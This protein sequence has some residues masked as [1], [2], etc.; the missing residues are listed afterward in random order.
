MKPTEDRWTMMLFRG[1]T[2][3]PLKISV[4]KTTFKRVLLA[5][6]MLSAV[7]AGVLGHYMAQ[8]KQ[9]TTQGAELE[10]LQEELS[11]SRGQ[12]VELFAAVD[13]MRQRVLTIQTLNEKLQ[14]MFGLEPERVED[15]AGWQGTRRRG[16]AVCG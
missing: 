13:K 4:R 2:A 12:A 1:T 14:V 15:D 10:G 7:Q 11:Q 6:V 16:G 3:T 8:K 9:V 5:V